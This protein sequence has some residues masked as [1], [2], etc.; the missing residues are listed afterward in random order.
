MIASGYMNQIG[1]WLDEL[2]GRPNIHHTVCTMNGRLDLLEQ[3]MPPSLTGFVCTISRREV[4]LGFTT[5][6]WNAVE[7]RL[8]DL[9][10]AGKLVLRSGN[11][12]SQEENDANIQT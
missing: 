7:K 8:Q 5:R 10:V 6:K 3:T 11:F 4:T 12:D 2:K 9:K 1:T